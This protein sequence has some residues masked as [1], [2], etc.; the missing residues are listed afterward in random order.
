M[1]LEPCITAPRQIFLLIQSGVIDQMQP[2]CACYPLELEQTW[3]RSVW[4]H[5]ASVLLWG[6]ENDFSPCEEVMALS[7]RHHKQAKS[8]C[9]ESS[10]SVLSLVSEN[11]AAHPICFKRCTSS[12]TLRG[13]APLASLL[14]DT[15]SMKHLSQ[16]SQSLRQVIA[17]ETSH[18]QIILNGGRCG[19][20]Q[21]T[22]LL[23][24]PPHTHTLKVPIRWQA[25]KEQRRW[26]PRIEINANSP[27]ADRQI[28]HSSSSGGQTLWCYLTLTSHYNCV[29]V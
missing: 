15:W 27:C 13:P 12:N 24:P 16:L 28:L 22:S 2:L 19:Y 18:L 3:G 6:E 25:L 11:K 20:F 4:R 7:D 1:H 26:V 8:K 23:P 5:W 14:W 17:V 10:S 29:Q 21:M 9:S